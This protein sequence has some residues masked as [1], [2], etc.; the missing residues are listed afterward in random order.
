MRAVGDAAKPSEL[1]PVTSRIPLS[2]RA[3][4]M[5]GKVRSAPR[6]AF[7]HQRDLSAEDPGDASS[8]CYLCLKSKY[9]SLPS[10][11]RYMYS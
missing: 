1:V 7:A 4:A 8:P 5:R 3:S 10:W 2:G 6:V 11:Q 9:T